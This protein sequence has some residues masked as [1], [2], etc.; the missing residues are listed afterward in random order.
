ML[1][2]IKKTKKNDMVWIISNLNTW[3]LWIANK[4]LMRKLRLC[5]NRGLSLHNWTNHKT[6]TSNATIVNGS[7]AMAIN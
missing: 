2:R 3:S 7:F 1:F 4:L 6:K 5:T